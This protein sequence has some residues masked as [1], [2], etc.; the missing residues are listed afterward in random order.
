[1]NKK[2]IS[3]LIKIARILLVLGMMVVL[4]LIVCQILSSTL[5]IWW[6]CLGWLYFLIILIMSI[7]DSVLIKKGI[8]VYKWRKMRIWSL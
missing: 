7:T 4:I 8:V 2:S 3:S 1:M 5:S 6:I